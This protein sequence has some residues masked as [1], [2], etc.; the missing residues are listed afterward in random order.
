M[1]EWWHWVILG[2]CL[3]VAELIIP[4][5]F[6]IWF[7]IGALCVG[8]LLFAFPA[9]STAVQLIVWTAV[10]SGL[11][12]VWYHYFKPKTVTNIG[13][14]IANVIGEI[15]ILVSDL[16]PDSRGQ[17]RFQKPILGSDLWECYAEQNFKA[18]DRVRIAA[19]EGSF[20]KVES[21]K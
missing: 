3:L 13:T 7:G 18:G 9:L 2:L 8:L 6:V 4:A 16:S 17:I 5:F 14:S 10:S 15:G 21:I 1:F 20:I 19:V 12:V 11:V